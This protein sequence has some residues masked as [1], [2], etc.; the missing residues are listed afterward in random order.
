[1]NKI[2]RVVLGMSIVLAVGGGLFWYANETVSGREWQAKI[3]ALVYPIAL[4]SPKVKDEHC[5]IEAYGAVSGKEN[6]ATTAINQAITDCARQGG[7]I[8]VVPQGQWFTG[9]IRLASHITLQLDAGAELIFDPNIHRYLPVVFTRFQGMELYNYTPLIYGFELENVAITGSGKLVGNGDERAK[10]DGE[11]EFGAARAKL[12]EMAEQGVPVAERVF[13]EVIPGLRPSFVQCVRCRQ[14]RF[15]DFTIENGPFWTIHLIYSEDVMVRRI[16][17]NT[18]SINTDGIVIDST[19]NVVIEDS[20][21]AT[22]DDAIAIKSGTDADGRRVNMP[23]ENIEIRRVHVTKGNSGTSLGS[24]MSGGIRNVVVRDSLFE[25]TGSGFR[26]KTNAGRGGFFQNIVVDNIE[27]KQIESNAI[28]IDFQ[29]HSV[30]KSKESFD[31]TVRNVAIKNIHGTGV[32][33]AMINVD[34]IAHIDLNGLRMEHIHFEAVEYPV[35]IEYANNLVLK[36]ISFTGTSNTGYVLEES[37][38]ITVEDGG[39]QKQ[40]VKS[41]V[42]IIGKHTDNLQLRGM[43]W[44]PSQTPV[45]IEGGAF[46]KAVSIDDSLNTSL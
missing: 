19:K 42:H 34:G 41:C 9:G 26:M 43:K 29:Y 11:G 20:T 31:T 24:E 7:G 23:S 6:D 15:E 40:G 1:M 13:G 45:I 37:K 16:H 27:M 39:C 17:V 32:K 35:R 46:E 25:H 5:R 33:E 18:W 2:S 10:W 3:R 21:F 8:V 44:L 12:Y 30:L 22:G 28:N 4:E 38:N 36:D 14:V